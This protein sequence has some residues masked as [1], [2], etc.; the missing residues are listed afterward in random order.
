MKS[1]VI[2]LGEVVE[3][4]IVDAINIIAAIIAIA[5]I[6]PIIILVIIEDVKNKLENKLLRRLFECG[7]I[8][9]I[10][11]IVR[12]LIIRYNMIDKLQSSYDWILTIC[13]YITLRD[14]LYGI[15]IVVVAVSIIAI[16]KYLSNLEVAHCTRKDK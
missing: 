11:L 9:T 1:E 6:S 4:L 2:T 10:L 3:K 14:I 15:T 8:I 12:Y 7:E 13:G 16:Y 5:A